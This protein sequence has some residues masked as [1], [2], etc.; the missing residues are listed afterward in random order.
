MQLNRDLLMLVNPEGQQASV[1]A[2]EG[3]PML[4][5]MT[6]PPLLHS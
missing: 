6:Q 1:G 5:S 3:Q 2:M 4:V